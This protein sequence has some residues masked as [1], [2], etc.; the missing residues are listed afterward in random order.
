MQLTLQCISS[1]Q[2]AEKRKLFQNLAKEIQIREDQISE[3]PG[4]ITE[5]VNAFICTVWCAPEEQ[6]TVVGKPLLDG[7]ELILKRLI[8]RTSV[9]RYTVT[10]RNATRNP[11]PKPTLQEEVTPRQS[12]IR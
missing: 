12:A 4:H 6:R 10:V 11:L 8:S 1:L 9:R 5:G 7:I 3:A 2:S